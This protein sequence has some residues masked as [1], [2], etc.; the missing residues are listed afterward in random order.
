MKTQAIKN[1]TSEKSENKSDFLFT[2]ENYYIMAVGL[3]F[4]AL[5]FILMIGG[6]SDD[7]TVFNENI[8]NAQ[9][10]TVAPILLVIGYIIEIFA[11][12]YKKKDTNKEE[13]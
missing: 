5:G 10:L 9:R 6:G 4:I 11:I 3:V 13:I 8:F 1:Q 7:P 2:K 12:F